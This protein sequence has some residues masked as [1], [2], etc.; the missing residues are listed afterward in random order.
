MI[1]TTIPG[2]KT[3]TLQHLVLDYN[4]TLACDGDLIKGVRDRLTDL[5]RRLR[6]HVIT[7]DTFGKV[8]ASLSGIPCELTI[9]PLENQDEGKRAYVQQLGPE[10]TVSIGNGRNDCL[11]LETAALGIVVVQEEGAATRTVMAADIVCP[12]I[13]SALDLLTNPK[14]LIATLRS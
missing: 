2:Y 4:G 3:L 10:A 12:N 5:A 6:I 9:L 7:A 11:M 13:L 8:R 1:E 14:R